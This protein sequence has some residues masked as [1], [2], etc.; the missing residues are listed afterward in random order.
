MAHEYYAELYNWQQV[1]DE[2]FWPLTSEKVSLASH[3]W[4]TIPIGDHFILFRGF[5]VYIMGNLG[6]MAKVGCNIKCG[7]ETLQ[8]FDMRHF[9]HME[10]K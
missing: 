9:S 6:N 4:R 5:P 8:G 10:L 3:Q 7:S 1:L 2:S